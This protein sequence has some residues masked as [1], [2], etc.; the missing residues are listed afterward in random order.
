[1]AGVRHLITFD[2]S[3][4]GSNPTQPISLDKPF[5]R[6]DFTCWAIASYSLMSASTSEV[7]RVA[8]FYSRCSFGGQPMA[9]AG[10]GEHEPDGTEFAERIE[11]LYEELVNL[12][13]LS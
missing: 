1:M 5:L 10:G 13:Y 2:H 7:G 12:G 11:R 6:G 8:S 9:K 4:L 3:A